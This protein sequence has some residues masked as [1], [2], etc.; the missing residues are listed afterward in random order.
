M[1][2]IELPDPSAAV[3]EVSEQTRRCRRE[4]LDVAAARS[5]C[6]SLRHVADLDEQDILRELARLEFIRR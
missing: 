3:D 5:R 1:V 2:Y 4:L 6:A